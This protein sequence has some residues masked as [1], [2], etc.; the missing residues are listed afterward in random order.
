MACKDGQV[1]IWTD[2]RK[3]VNLR[4]KKDK[5]HQNDFIVDRLTNS[6]VNTISGDSFP[7]EV[8]LLVKSDLKDITK[9]RGWL[10][11]WKTELKATDREI[12]KLTITNNLH[13]IQGLTSLTIK[14]DHVL[15]QLIENAPFN[16]GKDKLYE[17]VP[18]NLVA[19]ACRLS[20]HRGNDGF[21]SFHSK[22]N[23]I[24]HYIKS[25]GA[26]HHGNHLM[27]IETDAATNLVNKYFKL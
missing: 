25:L 22:T 14:P 2:D 19:F 24:D 8:S 21:V 17:G 9:K 11:D 18:G 27:V 4:V 5:I 3:S 23:L 12:Y 16:R 10:F 15:I 20:F 13:V 1:A 26:I 6:I 7:T